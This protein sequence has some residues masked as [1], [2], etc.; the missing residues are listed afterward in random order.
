MVVDLAGQ[1][2]FHFIEIFVVGLA[3][4]LGGIESLA[5]GGAVLTRADVNVGFFGLSLW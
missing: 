2:C 1:P 4:D 3:V 5:I